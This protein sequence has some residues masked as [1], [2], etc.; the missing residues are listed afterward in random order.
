MGILSR[1]IFKECFSYFLICLST[2]TALILTARILKFTNLIVNKGV[3][4]S[5]IVKLFLSIIPTFLEIAIPMSVLLG[6]ML[7]FARLSG[8]S[9]IV[10]IRASGITIK[11][12]LKPILIFAI[13][14]SSFS[15]YVSL[16]LRPYGYRLFNETLFEIAKTKSTAGITAGF[17]NKLGSITVYTEDIDYKSGELG[18]TLIDDKRNAEGRK[19][20]ISK[21]GNISSDP[22]SQQILINLKEGTIH[23]KNKKEYGITNFTTNK[24]ILAPEDLYSDISLKKDNRGRELSVSDLESRL[25]FYKDKIKA[26]SGVET[27]E[28]QKELSKK[29]NR[30]RLEYA[31]RYAMPFISFIL[32]LLAVPLGIMPPRTQKTWG[33]SFSLSVGIGMF[34]LYYGILS[35]GMALAEKGSINPYIAVWLPNLFMSYVA[36][37]A[38]KKTSSESWQSVSDGFDILLG[39][40]LKRKKVDAI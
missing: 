10:V 17:F 21:S 32:A 16:Q 7:A 22:R 38:I 6:L 33:A 37:Y 4:F 27:L 39:K 28:V 14:A 35:F 34:V 30:F 26:S 13:L 11:Q 2:F 40:I 19:I 12:L 23:Q 9:E 31:L 29:Y 25:E 3:E 18:N 36:Y 5:N 1:Y 15:Y 24:L 20:I 8:D